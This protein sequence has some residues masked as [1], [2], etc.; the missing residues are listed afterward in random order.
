MADEISFN[1]GLTVSKG[2]ISVS[3]S[4][5]KRLTLTGTLMMNAPQVISTA[6]ELI[7]LGDLPS[8][9]VIMLFNNDETDSIDLSLNVGMT[10]PLGTLGPGEMTVIP[11]PSAIY[12]AASANTPELQVV[13][14]ED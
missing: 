6:P 14:C 9:K 3:L 12:A 5:S 4:K 13:A 10:Q 2:G 1:A 8:A 11:N 7:D